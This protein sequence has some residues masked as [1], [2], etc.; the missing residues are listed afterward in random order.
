[1]DHTVALVF[2]G[3]GIILIVLEMA[4]LTFYLAALGFASLLTSLV[5]WVYP[6]QD[7]QAAAVFAV[8][9]AVTLPLAHLL[10][11]AVDHGC[12]SPEERRRAGKP[13]ESTIRLE[14]RHSAGMLVVIVSD[15]GAGVDVARVRQAIVNKK[16]TTAEVA[17]KMNESELLEFLFVVVF[18]DDQTDAV[19]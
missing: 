16:L 18:A 2:L 3:A 12:E 4:S 10:R 14:A 8:A 5:T 13:P 17:E 19:K 6:V 15:D 9:S 11:N 7:W 1:M